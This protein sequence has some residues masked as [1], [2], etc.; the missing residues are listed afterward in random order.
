MKVVHVFAKMF[1]YILHHL[2]KLTWLYAAQLT[3]AHKVAGATLLT[4]LGEIS[5]TLNCATCSLSESPTP[6][7]HNR[8]PKKEVFKHQLPKGLP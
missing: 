6:T 5:E 7:T 3:S 8:L 2:Q 4:L 1:C